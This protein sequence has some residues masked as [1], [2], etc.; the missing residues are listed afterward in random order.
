MCWQACTGMN[1]CNITDTA[2]G[3]VAFRADM[4]NATNLGRNRFWN[5]D[6]DSVNQDTDFAHAFSIYFLISSIVEIKRMKAAF[7]SLSLGCQL[8]HRD[9]CG[10][11]FRHRLSAAF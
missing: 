5:T 10:K 1:A 3:A 9:V 6:C 2:C 11:Q 7:Q 8:L 4:A